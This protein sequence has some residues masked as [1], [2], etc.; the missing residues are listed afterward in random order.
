M[1]VPKYLFFTKGIGVHKEKI[2]S[3]EIALRDAGI[4]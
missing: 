2:A 3:L 1:Y 4:A